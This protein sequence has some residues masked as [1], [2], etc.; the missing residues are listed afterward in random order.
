[1]ERQERE[2]LIAEER[3]KHKAIVGTVAKGRS[4]L[5][6]HPSTKIPKAGS[7]E[8][9]HLLQGEVRAGMEESR[10]S[11]MVA[12]GQQGA[13]T[14]WENVVQRRILWADFWRPNFNSTTFLI[15]AV[16]DTLPSPANLNIWGKSDTPSCPL[17]ERRGTLQHILSNC[18]KA[19]GEGRYRWRHDQVLGVIVDTLNTAIRT[20]VFD[21]NKRSINF[22]K[23]GDKAPP[24]KKKKKQQN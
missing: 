21:P 13:W 17:C 19:L 11:T 9:Q 4:G 18:P 23:A 1:M 16:Y 22:I 24:Q 10:M 8:H 6:Y 14:K 15:Q 20:S 7:K 5:G 12:L 2:L 3:L